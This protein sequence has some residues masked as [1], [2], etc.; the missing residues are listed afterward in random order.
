M[1]NTFEEGKMC[2]ELAPNSPQ[3]FILSLEVNP[4]V[5]PPLSTPRDQ[6]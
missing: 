5:R 3:N 4:R 1:Q 2:Q 6:G